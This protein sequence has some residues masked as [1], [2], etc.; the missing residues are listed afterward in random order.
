MEHLAQRIVIG[1]V[2][3]AQ[4]AFGGA[5]ASAQLLSPPTASILLTTN[6]GAVAAAP[7]PTFAGAIPPTPPVSDA[8]KRDPLPPELETS[9]D[10]ATRGPATVRARIGFL[11]DAVEPGAEIVAL[12]ILESDQT[13]SDVDVSVVLPAGLT[14]SEP[15]TK[16][17]RFD[18]AT[19]T[20][21]WS[22]LS[23]DRLTS[24]QPFGLKVAPG[25]NGV[26]LSLR[27]FGQDTPKR[28]IVGSAS[29]LRVGGRVQAKQIDLRGGAL[30]AA[31]GRTRLEFPPG[32][33]DAETVF[34][35][36]EVVA[37]TGAGPSA[38]L[39][40]NT[41]DDEAGPARTKP[42]R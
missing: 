10:S 16:V 39:R 41:A 9:A 32:A 15:D 13:V 5:P 18:P 1:L 20:L 28:R 11:K 40:R 27:P 21:T 24:F 6:G 14:Y 42:T 19:R 3:A 22:G 38:L 37:D 29:T 23:A 8:K 34:T 25:N 4:A 33:V 35:I 36:T 17:T 12:L 2:I 26:L 30:A 7:A 31:D